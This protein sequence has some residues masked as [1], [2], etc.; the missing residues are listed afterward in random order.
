MSN[1]INGIRAE[2]IDF[3]KYEVIELLEDN[4]VK[5]GDISRIVRLMAELKELAA[6]QKPDY[7]TEARQKKGKV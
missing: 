5:E 3:I 1:Q 7:L 6:N 4:K 2:R